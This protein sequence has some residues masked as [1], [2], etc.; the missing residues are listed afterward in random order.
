M[1]IP[2]MRQLILHQLENFYIISEEEKYLMDEEIIGKS[3]SSTQ[4]C[5]EKMNFKYYI[6]QAPS[7]RKEGINLYNSVMNCIFLY[8]LSRNLFLDNKSGLADKIYCLNKALNCVELFYEVNLPDIWLCDHPLGSVMGR[9]QY[10]NY[11]FFYQ[12]CTVGSNFRK[13]GTFVHPIIGQHVKMLSH[14]KILGNC[15]IG[16]HT[17]ISANCYIKDQDVPSNTIVFGKSPNLIFKKNDFRY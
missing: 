10:G 8:W 14:S 9:A 13:D 1:K 11:F 7:V 3:T 15:R 17:I 5:L 16:D 2:E 6:S 4:Y 12:G